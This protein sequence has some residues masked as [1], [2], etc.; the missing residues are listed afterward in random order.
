MVKIYYLE[1]NNTPFY[2][3]KS[4]NP[5]RRIHKH[6]EKFGNDIQLNIIDDVEEENWKFWEMYWISQF[7]NWGFDLEN[8]N[9]GGGGPT[10]WTEKQREN[11]NPDRI[12][13]IKNHPTRGFKISKSLKER[14]HSKYYTK[15][16]RQKIS[17]KLK[18][19]SKQFTKEHLIN[20]AEANLKSKGK[21]VECYTLEDKFICDFPCLKGAKEWITKKKS[22]SSPNVDKQIKDCCNGRQKTCHG[23]KW[24]YKSEDS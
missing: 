11:I 7:K 10:K 3:G 21:I 23:F 9:D 4:K 17:E 12:L 1:R 8:K 15:E 2:V 18:G 6:Y 14:N 19:V 13:K 16:I 24:K 20:L 22:L 5:I